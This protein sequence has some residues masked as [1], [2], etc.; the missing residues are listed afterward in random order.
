LENGRIEDLTQ[1]MAF[2]SDRIP[3]HI[4]DLI[5]QGGLVASLKKQFGAT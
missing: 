1:S 5:N 2:D 3:S 4:M